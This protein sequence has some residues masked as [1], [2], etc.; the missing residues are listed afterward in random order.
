M[1]PD[2]MIPILEIGSAISDTAHTVCFGM[3]AR[4]GR[5]SSPQPFA[6]IRRRPRLSG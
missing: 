4:L 1:F 2:F 5:G 3:A 6:D